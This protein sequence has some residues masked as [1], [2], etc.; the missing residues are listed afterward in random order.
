MGVTTNFRADIQPVWLD[1]TDLQHI[2]V[3]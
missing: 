2:G 3:L 1:D